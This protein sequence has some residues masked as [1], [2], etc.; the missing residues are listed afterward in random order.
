[1]YKGTSHI[2]ADE[3]FGKPQALVWVVAKRT[4]R[5]THTT[6]SDRHM[7]HRHT[8]HHVRETHASLTHT[9]SRE[10]DICVTD[11]HDHGKLKHV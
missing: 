1:M 9:P 2:A 8:H 6:V 10:A 3:L 4:A 5:V 11:T 7:R